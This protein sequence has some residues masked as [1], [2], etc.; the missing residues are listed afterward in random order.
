M[1]LGLALIFLLP[2]ACFVAS[3]IRNSTLRKVWSC[4]CGLML[5]FYAQ[6]FSYTMVIMC[7]LMAYVPIMLLPRF[8]GSW[9]SVLIA[10]T[11]LVFFNYEDHK[12]GIQMEK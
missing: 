9:A 7:F 1:A 5:G 4:T 8:Y 12:H 11:Q 6:G 10:T 2:A 3:L